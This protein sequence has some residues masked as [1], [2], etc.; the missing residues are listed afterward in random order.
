M[1][2][3]ERTGPSSTPRSLMP[4]YTQ[5]ERPLSVTTPLGPDVLLLVGVTG[6]EALSELFRFE[7]ELLAENGVDVAFEK[8]LG[9]KVTARIRLTEQTNRYIGGVVSRVSQGA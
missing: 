5:A 4:T 9:Q 6:R 8:L 1:S 3:W 7:L 2:A